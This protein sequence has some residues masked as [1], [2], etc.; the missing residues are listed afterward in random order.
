MIVDG[1]GMA[2]QSSQ[3]LTGSQKHFS[4]SAQQWL[5]TVNMCMCISCVLSYLRITSFV[6][7]H[8]LKLT[9]GTLTFQ[10]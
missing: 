5:V 10:Q 6:Q 1:A 8:T 7:P 3:L 9:Q 2:N 4:L